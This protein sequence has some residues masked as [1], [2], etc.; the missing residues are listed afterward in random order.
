LRPSHS[1]SDPK[2][3]ARGGYR[4]NG[5]VRG[6][7]V[8]PFN[9]V[10]AHEVLSSGRLRHVRPDIK[11]IFSVC[12]AAAILGHELAGTVVAVVHGVKS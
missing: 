9:D 3:H 5:I 8:S 12:R 2:N 4:E 7:E 6:E 1:G 11:K 10:R